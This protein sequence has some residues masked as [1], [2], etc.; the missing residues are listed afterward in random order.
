MT[1]AKLYPTF[2]F[3]DAEAGMQFLKDAFGF[4][5]HS[6]YRSDDGTIRHAELKLGDDMVMFGEGDPGDNGI[7]AAV[8]DVDAVYAS[9]KKAGATITRE[10]NDTDYGSREFGCRDLDGHTWSI[11]TYRP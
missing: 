2:R 1:N 3:R 4:A 7:Y 5:E 10:L 6:I 9:A 8:E 11:G